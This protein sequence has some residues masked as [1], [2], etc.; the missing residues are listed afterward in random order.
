MTISLLANPDGSGTIQTGG[1]SAINISTS[2]IVSFPVGLAPITI[3]GLNVVSGLTVSG[4]ANISG[5]ST[6]S[7]GLDITSNGLT[8]SGGGINV[9]SGTI[10][11][12][13]GTT[14]LPPL[15]FTLGALLTTPVAGAMEFDGNAFYATADVTCGRG[16]I[17]APHYFRLTSD[18]SAISTIANFFGPTSGVSLD[19][20]TFFE[21]EA[22]LYFTKTTA[23]TATFT[24]TFSNA[25]INN[26]AHYVGSQATGVGAVGTPQTAAL[27]KSTATAG[28]L[29]ATGS[30]TTSANHQYAIRAMFQTNATTGGT[31]DLRI[32]SSAGTV[33]PLTGS[34]YKLTRLPAANVGTFV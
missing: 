13:A 28:A 15:D 6:V 29:P 14:T 30:L 8:V 10:T 18:G 34:Y 5:A 20:S 23:G 26:N 4:G 12:A 16:F 7:G 22:Y 27:I 2:Q 32:T 17:Q 1:V 19:P 9:S 31:L 33:T 21:L 25:P 24:M 3:S 11:M